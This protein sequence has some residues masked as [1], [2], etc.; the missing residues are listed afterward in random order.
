[1][2]SFLPFVVVGVRKEC[3]REGRGR[4]RGRR[5]R[6]GDEMKGM[7][8][9]DSLICCCNRILLEKGIDVN[10]KDIGGET[11]LHVAA[12]LGYRVSNVV[13]RDP[14]DTTSLSLSEQ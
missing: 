6:R 8:A 11:A 2:A 13:P 12:G 7:R 1:M 5:G 10:S 9:D 3:K 4:G 14:L